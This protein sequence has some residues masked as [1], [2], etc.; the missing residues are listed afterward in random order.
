MQPPETRPS[1]IVRLQ[2]KRNELAWTEF[3]SAYEPFLQR[4]IERPNVK[5]ER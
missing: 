3:V 4:L 2:G 5:I 1:L